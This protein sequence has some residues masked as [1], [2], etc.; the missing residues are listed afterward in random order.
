MVE[1]QVMNVM[2]KVGV[3]LLGG[4]A[5]VT[6]SAAELSFYPQVPYSNLA[7]THRREREMEQRKDEGGTFQ[8]D[9]DHKVLC[10]HD[11]L[12]Y[13]ALVRWLLATPISD[14][15][16]SRSCLCDCNLDFGS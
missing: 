5:G 1:V 7:G 6:P 15:S 4:E 10:Y 14:P 2:W 16:F 12:L 3:L 8:F 13:E 11:N 9:K